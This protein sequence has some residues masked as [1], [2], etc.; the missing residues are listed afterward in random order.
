MTSKSWHLK[1]IF[2]YFFQK[3]NVGKRIPEEYLGGEFYISSRKKITACLNPLGSN[4]PHATTYG[5]ITVLVFINMNYLI[6]MWKVGNKNCIK[7]RDLK[8]ITFIK[9]WQD[10]YNV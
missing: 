7:A 3:K 8:L 5:L 6:M 10:D 2:K 1:N 9:W 4:R